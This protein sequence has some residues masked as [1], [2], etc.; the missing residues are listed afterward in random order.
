[1]IFIRTQK[2]PLWYWR[3]FSFNLLLETCRFNKTQMNPEK[4]FCSWL[5][6][7]SLQ[8][9]PWLFFFLLKQVILIPSDHRLHARCDISDIQLFWFSEMNMYLWAII[10][11]TLKSVRARQIYE[12]W[13][14]QWPLPMVVLCY[15]C[16]RTRGSKSL[17]MTKWGLIQLESSF[18]RFLWSTMKMNKPPFFAVSWDKISSEEGRSFGITGNICKKG[19]FEFWFSSYKIHIHTSR[20]TF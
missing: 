14:D 5:F 9:C 2:V 10:L 7:T 20:H 18:S 12:K 8:P 4:H 1:M 17:N 6:G 15:Y 16:S 3:V 19:Y 11:M 13:N